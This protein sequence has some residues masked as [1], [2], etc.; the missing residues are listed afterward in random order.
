MDERT[1]RTDNEAMPKL[2]RAPPAPSI[3]KRRGSR[4]RVGVGLIVLIGLIVAAYEFV[5]WTRTGRQ[6]GGRPIPSQPVGA[7]TIGQGDIRGVVNALGTVTP[8][9]TVTVQTQINGQL[10]EVG[11]TEGQLSRRAISWRR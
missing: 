8:A 4:I 1:R 5:P 9:A 3:D 6:T 2:R 7:A 11:F 10:L